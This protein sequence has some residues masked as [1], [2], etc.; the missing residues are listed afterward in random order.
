MLH[1]VN[2]D[3]HPNV[4][5]DLHRLSVE[6]VPVDSYPGH[7]YCNKL[8]QLKSL[9][10]REFEDVALLDCDVLVLE[11]PPTA[12]GGV[13]AK[14][15]DFGN[16]EIET[17]TQIFNV[18]G[19]TFTLATADIDNAP[20]ALANANGGVYVISH[21][22]FDPL[23]RE[24]RRWADWC[25]AH[26]DM[27]GDKSMRIDQVSFAMAIA[28]LGIPFA[29]LDRRFNVPTHIPQPLGLDCDPA[30]LH[31]HRAV[32]NQQL[33]LTVQGLPQVNK[34]IHAINERILSERRLSFD[35]A[36]FWNAR[37]T[38]H[39]DLGSGVGS[40]G[41]ILARKQQ[42]LREVV[43]ILDVHS[44]LD[45]GSGDGYT[46]SALP[47]E[48]S[49]HAADLAASSRSLYLTAVPRASWMQHDI[50]SEP[51]KVNADLVV[52]LDVLIHIS[53]ND[54]YQSA[55]K[56]LLANG[57]PVLVSGFDAHPVEFGPMTY[58]HEPLSS[59]IRDLGYVA[60]PVDAYRGL[61][62]FIAMPPPLLSSTRDISK[63]TLIDA[64]TLVAEPLLLVEAVSLSRSKL[65]FF[66]DHL[67]RCIEYPWVA[68]QLPVGKAMRIV[69]AGAGVS[70]LPFM[71]ADRGHT[72]ITVDPHPLARIDT[73]PDSWNEWGFLDY[74]RLDSR[75]S[76]Q[77]I[78]YQNTSDD[79]HLDAVVSVSVIEHLP[80]AIRNAWIKKAYSQLVPGGCIFLTV[81]TV[82]FSRALWNYSE[83]NQVE[84]PE[85]HGS[86][87][88]LE[89]ELAGAGFTVDIVEHSVWLPKSRVGMAR[90]KATK[91]RSVPL[92]GYKSH[93]SGDN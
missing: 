68:Q 33:F 87:D 45:V 12:K 74:S 64:I 85:V 83:G 31:Y 77:H 66:P 73:P 90:I 27:F 7:P 70:V 91:N 76:S 81:D 17:L 18:A 36:V 63:S 84:D 39:P 10:G 72:V 65:G 14:P 52:C 20:T 58:F 93:D 80:S 35:N 71:L 29:E 47:E 34:A 46:A 42:L 38:L 5:A 82:P 44:I 60:F 88:I 43:R 4:L 22:Q 75:I 57:E 3:S 15:V 23:A 56:N 9:G 89:S 50:T 16:P 54:E 92:K 24:W 61:S 37:Y 53:A 41:T 40:R 6:V 69:D 2:A 13:L 48:V 19:L 78:P 79:L 28:S 11:Q 21:Q 49:V 1:V 62:A 55:V 8:Q 86:I 51:V 67:P 25:I 32:D 59:T 26:I 30:I